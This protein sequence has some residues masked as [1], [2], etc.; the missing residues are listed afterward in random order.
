VTTDL[1]NPAS[2][3]SRLG[4]TYPD[5]KDGIPG[6]I[7]GL[8]FH[9]LCES[10]SYALE[11]VL[12]KVEMNFGHLLPELE[13]INMGGGHLITREDYDRD[14]LIMTLRRFQDKYGLKIIMEP[15]SAIAWQTG[16]LRSKVLDVVEN[17]GVKT[18]IADIS[19]TC[20]MPDCLEMPY[21]PVLRG[22]KTDIENGD[23]PYRI[24]GVS[25]LAGDF[26]EAY[27]FTQE[28]KPGD[29]LIFEDMIHYTM[30]KT[31]TF[32]GVRHPSIGIIDKDGFQL[33]REFG[34]DD[35]KNRL[36]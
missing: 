15:G 19:F 10:D 27:G 20:H 26:M 32:N 21:K 35:Y 2:P 3:N 22:A 6:E 34:Y 18:A 11:R 23:I 28:L 8:H 14:H 1:Y 9:V 25:C 31:T 16:F 12:S 24:G 30:V 36:S 33:V 13:W 29:D 7:S 5:L 17:H 4:I